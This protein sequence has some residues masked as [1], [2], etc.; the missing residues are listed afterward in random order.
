MNLVKNIL[1][2][3]TSVLMLL[4]TLSPL[5]WYSCIQLVF[6]FIFYCSFS[7]L[8]FLLLSILYKWGFYLFL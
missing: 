4:I 3:S 6:S 1:D 7:M 5:L 8:Y 2:G